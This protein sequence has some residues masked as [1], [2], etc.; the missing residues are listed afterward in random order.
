MIISVHTLSHS[1]TPS[2]FVDEHSIAFIF[3]FF[4]PKNDDDDDE[5]EVEMLFAECSFI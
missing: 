2:V 1:H 4:L 5:N 3:C